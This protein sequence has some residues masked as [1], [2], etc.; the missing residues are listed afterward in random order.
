[1]R[2]SGKFTPLQIKDTMMARIKKGIYRA[3]ARVGI[4]YMLAPVM[5]VYTGKPG[6]NT[7][8]TMNMPHF[9]FYAPYITNADVGIVPNSPHGP[10]LLNS[11]YSPEGYLIMP[12]DKE[13]SAK[14]IADGKDLLKR[15][16]DYNACFK[17]SAPMHH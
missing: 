3:P 17:V 5:R 6:D 15:L 2:A 11:T 14:I 8:M 13:E 4:S 7:V 16:E 10:W 1:M 9:M 12:A